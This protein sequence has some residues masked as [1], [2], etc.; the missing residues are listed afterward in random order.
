MSERPYS[1]RIHDL[2]RAIARLEG[3][4]FGCALEFSALGY[5]D[6]LRIDGVKDGEAE[7]FSRLPCLR[8][9]ADELNAATRPI[10]EAYA[11]RLRQEMA[12]EC[13]KVA[14]RALS[15]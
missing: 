11:K 2:E 5:T 12:N 6:Q 14:A 1:G 13:T 10:R 15:E 9:F 7:H 4:A 8:E 3:W